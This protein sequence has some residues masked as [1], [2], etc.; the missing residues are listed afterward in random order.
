MWPPCSSARPA[1]ATRRCSRSTLR[2][3]H[4]FDAHDV[5]W[6]FTDPDF[7]HTIGQPTVA[8]MADGTWVAVFGNG[9]NSDNHRAVLFIVRL[10]DG[11]LLKKIDTGVGDVRS[12]ERPRDTRRC[13]PTA[14]A[15]F[16]AIYA[17]DLP[18]TS[19]SS[20]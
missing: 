16:A 19:G 2:D 11:V 10:E 3:P 8:R 15:R 12:A 17:G 1:R 7:G 20:T 9:Y 13:S 6:E 18:A 5:L 14:R 4:S